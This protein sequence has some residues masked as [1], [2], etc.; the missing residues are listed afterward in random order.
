MGCCAASICAAATPAVYERLKRIERPGFAIDV[1]EYFDVSNDP[2]ESVAVMVSAPPTVDA[3]QLQWEMSLSV[4]PGKDANPRRRPVDESVT[5]LK[6]AMM[7]HFR[8]N[9]L[10]EPVI[11]TVEIPHTDGARLMTYRTREVGYYWWHYDLYVNSGADMYR[12]AAW[13]RARP[14]SD[15]LAADHPS[16][17]MLRKAL[18]T[19]RTAAWPA[20]QPAT[21]RPATPSLT[22]RILDALGD[23]FDDMLVQPQP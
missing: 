6:R 8:N 4:Q 12:V 15:V 19:F 11:E 23:E 14:G 13:R 16:A 20:T 1:P 9:L 5:M 17:A 10:D 18:L 7:T 21:T 2:A 3:R 22:P